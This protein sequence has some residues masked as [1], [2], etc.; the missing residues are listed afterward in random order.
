MS[1]SATDTAPIALGDLAAMPVTRLKGVG[2]RKAEGLDA[3][4]VTSLLDLLTYYPRRYVDRTN[5]ARI[6]DLVVGEDALVLVTVERVASR[7]TRGRPP[8]VLVTVD[9]TDGSGHLRVSFFNQ[10]WRERQLRPGMTVALFGK[11]EVYAGRK[12][13][14]NPVVDLIGDRT[15]RI[16]PIYPQSDKAGLSTW[17]IGDWVAEVLR[18]SQ[19]RGLLDPVPDWV[20]D[21]FDLVARREAFAGIHA[22]ET[23]EHKEVAR[24]RLV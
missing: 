5:E 18:R 22:P 7:R 10:A 13:M 15:G 20:L 23:M 1:D 3:V 11:L 6:G 9:V 4:G 19:V 8:K 21:R 12:Q 17:E 24:R 16:V 14:T 2:E